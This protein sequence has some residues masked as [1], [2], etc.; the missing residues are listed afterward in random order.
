M[1]DDQPTQTESF[2]VSGDNSSTAIQTGNKI[3]SFHLPTPKQ[4]HKDLRHLAEKVRMLVYQFESL[5]PDHPE[6]RQLAG[7][8]R[9]SAKQSWIFMVRRAQD[10]ISGGTFLTQ[11]MTP[12][13][14]HHRTSRS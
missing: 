9:R 4:D 12:G 1:S 7:D 8:S 2:S 6:L 5:A 10:R 13:P 14:Q 3:E 11:Q